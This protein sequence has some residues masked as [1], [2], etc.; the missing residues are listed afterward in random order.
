[1]L[2][3]IR[4]ICSPNEMVKIFESVAQV[5]DETCGLSLLLL[6]VLVMYRSIVFLL[7]E[8]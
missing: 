4:F 1:M 8:V 2:C 5:T 3:L 7:G 6:L